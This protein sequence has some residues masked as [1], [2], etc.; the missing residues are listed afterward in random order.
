MFFFCFLRQ[1]QPAVSRVPAHRGEEEETGR[2]VWHQG[3]ESLEKV[4][5]QSKQLFS[6]PQFAIGH[7][8]I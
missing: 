2:T 1:P 4:K 3:A 7:L 8:T 5:I 6:F